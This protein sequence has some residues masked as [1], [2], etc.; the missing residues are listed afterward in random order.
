MKAEKLFQ[1]C[2]RR[3]FSSLPP[4]LFDIV[5]HSNRILREPRLHTPSDPTHAAV[6][7]H[8]RWRRPHPKKGSFRSKRRLLF[9]RPF[10]QRSAAGPP[11]FEPRLKAFEKQRGGRRRTAEKDLG[12][13]KIFNDNNNKK[14]QTQCPCVS[15]TELVIG[16]E[17]SGVGDGDEGSADEV[18]YTR[19]PSPRAG[20][21]KAGEAA[22]QR[23]SSET[24]LMSKAQQWL[25][26]LLGA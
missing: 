22:L 3:R 21:T 23:H 2:P 20:R 7:S 18:C 15:K 26:L 13:A 6:T 1:T 17:R 9:H 24:I 10:I 4:N 11:A 14:V 25:L 8:C 12:G 5:R 19:R 16:R